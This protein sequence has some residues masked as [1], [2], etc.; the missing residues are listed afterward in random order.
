M[1]NIYQVVTVE[2]ANTY[3]NYLIRDNEISN[4]SSLKSEWMTSEEA[5]QFLRISAAQLRNLAS[6]G[7][8]PYHKLGRLNRYHRGELQDLLQ[9]NKRG[10]QYGY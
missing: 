9:K 1:R 4:F 8:V 10:G 5:A 7:K 3:P 2:R 6:N